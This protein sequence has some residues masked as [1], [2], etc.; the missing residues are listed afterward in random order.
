[1]PCTAELEQIRKS[2]KGKKTVYDQLSNQ[3]NG[4]LALLFSYFEVKEI[5]VT[6]AY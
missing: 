2:E 3:Y 6:A 1:M 5:N 4:R